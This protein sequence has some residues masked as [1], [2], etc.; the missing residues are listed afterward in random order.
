MS[1]REPTDDE[2]QQIKASHTTDGK[3]RCY[4]NNHQ[5]E[6]ESEI[7]YHHIKPYSEKGPTEVSNLAP[8]CKDHHRRIGTLSITEFRARLELETFFKVPQDRKLDDVL[9]EKIGSGKYG[10]ELKTEVSGNSIKVYF[11]DRT[12]AVELPL[13]DCP[14]THFKYFFITLPLTYIRNDGE[15]QPRPLE[16]KRLW[17]L[18][19]H[20]LTHTQLAPAIC[21][22]TNGSVLLFDG[23]H[24]SAAQIWAGRKEVECKVYVEPDT[25]VL[26]ETNLAAHDKFRQM[27]FFTSVLISKWADIFKEEWEEY[28]QMEG[29]KSEDGFVDFLV[30][31][32]KKKLDAL[33][34][35]RSHIY[36]SILEDS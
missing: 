36:D 31:K 15:L 11:E 7:E 19:G 28:V 29:E 26:K 23:Q 5:I 35:I 30:R 16:V 25:K 12:A 13:Y 14:A 18:Y 33:N 21:R 4:V 6:D 1:H 8:V 20:L 3:V 34:M 22:L 9:N 27:P 32:G 24:K 10:K 17:E 2:K